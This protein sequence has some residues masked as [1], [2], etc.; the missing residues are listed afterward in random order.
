MRGATLT[1]LTPLTP[2]MAQMASMVHA[3]SMLLA[4]LPCMVH[5]RACMGKG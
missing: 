4:L 3:Q 5:A 2:Q 1:T